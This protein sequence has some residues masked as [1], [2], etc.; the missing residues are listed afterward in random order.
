MVHD[1]EIR[2]AGLIDFLHSLSGQLLI[3]TIDDPLIPKRVLQWRSPSSRV[4][5]EFREADRFVTSP[6]SA[7]ADS[8][9]EPASRIVMVH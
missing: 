1:N 9:A 2:I 4:R 6:L 3:H 5:F 7:W 8:V